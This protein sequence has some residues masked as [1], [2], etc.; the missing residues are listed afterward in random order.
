MVAVELYCHHLSFELYFVIGIFRR[1]LTGP[2]ET[3]APSLLSLVVHPLKFL[4]LTVLPFLLLHH[5]GKTVRQVLHKS[6]HETNFSLDFYAVHPNNLFPSLF[7]GNHESF[8]T[9]LHVLFFHKRRQVVQ[10][11]T[12]QVLLVVNNVK[13]ASILE[14]FVSHGV[15]YLR[16]LY[17]R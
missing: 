12:T 13:F 17:E 15:H 14:P 9:L 11:I 7:L 4:L 3:I 1:F 5:D 2:L 6:Y 8:P 10:S 16:L